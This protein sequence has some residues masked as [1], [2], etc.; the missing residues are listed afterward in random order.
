MKILLQK[1]QQKM[2]KFQKLVKVEFGK[3]S[4]CQIAMEDR[5][6]LCLVLKRNFGAGVKQIARVLRLGPPTHPPYGTSAR[7]H[8]NALTSNWSCWNSIETTVSSPMMKLIKQN[9]TRE[10]IAH[11]FALLYAVIYW[12]FFGVLVLRLS[13]FGFLH[14]FQHT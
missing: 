1:K 5:I 7:R 14:Q 4:I 8:R 11:G 3:S 13:A 10:F 2:L 9:K 12:S 6:K